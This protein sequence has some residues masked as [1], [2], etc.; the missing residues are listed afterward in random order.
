[1]GQEADKDYTVQRRDGEVVSTWQSGFKRHGS[2]TA[3]EPFCLVEITECS[4]LSLMQDGIY[5]CI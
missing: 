2:G 4:P 1:M 3:C 5:I